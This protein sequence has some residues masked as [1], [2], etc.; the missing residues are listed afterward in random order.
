MS[1]KPTTRDDIK[2]GSAEPD[3]AGT[4]SA[5]SAGQSTKVAFERDHFIRYTAMS[6]EDAEAFLGK[7]KTA[8]VVDRGPADPR[9]HK[10]GARVFHVYSL[11]HISTQEAQRHAAQ[12]T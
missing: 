10:P 12:N 6:R 7:D 9:R 8:L 3:D 4:E 2:R 5:E 11:D 1:N